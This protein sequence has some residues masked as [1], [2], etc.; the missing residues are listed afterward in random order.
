MYREEYA[1]TEARLHIKDK[2]GRNG[3]AQCP[4]IYCTYFAEELNE[5]WDK[6]DAL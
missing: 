3:Y 4:Q 5:L 1:K 6:I 2:F